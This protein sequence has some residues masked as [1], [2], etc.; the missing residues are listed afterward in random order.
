VLAVSRRFL[1]A[2]RAYAESL[3]PASGDLTRFLIMT[4]GRSGSELLVSL[5]DSHPQI[6]CDGEIL[7]RKRLSPTRFVAGRAARA[8]RQ[9]MSAYGLKV[10]PQHLHEVQQLSGADQWLRALS[11]DGWHVIRIRRRNR[12]HQ[13]VSMLRAQLT[14]WHVH[15]HETFDSAEPLELNP[16]MVVGT[17]YFIERMETQVDHYVDGIEH[18]DLSYEENLRDR[19]DQEATVKRLCRQLDVTEMAGT[20]TLVRNSSATLGD[21]IKN[22]DEVAVEVRQS[23]FAEFLVE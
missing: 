7:A 4:S 22:Y 10:Q 5:L 16:L 15:A 19:I 23:R 9:G 11:A 20:S 17:M 1:G 6:A 8:Q 14:Q 18:I 12:L 13:A 21:L 3:S 2:A